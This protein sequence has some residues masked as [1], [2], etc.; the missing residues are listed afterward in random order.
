MTGSPKY[1]NITGRREYLSRDEMPSSYCICDNH[2]D[3][4]SFGVNS[5]YSV[6]FN[7]NQVI[8][9]KL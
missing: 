4:Q 9:L 3:Q 8:V 6:Q 1:D 5:A 2:N 7:A